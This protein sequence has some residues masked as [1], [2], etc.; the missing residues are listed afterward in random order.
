M[1][2]GGVPHEPMDDIM[3]QWR[4][5]QVTWIKRVAAHPDIAQCTER[6]RRALA[7]RRA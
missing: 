7:G 2:S 4:R 6:A 5:D 1:S 3:A